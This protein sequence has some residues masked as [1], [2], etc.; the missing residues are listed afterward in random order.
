M[1]NWA[2]VSY[3]IQSDCLSPYKAHFSLQTWPQALVVLELNPI[4]W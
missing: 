4:S 1:E 2:G 3:Q